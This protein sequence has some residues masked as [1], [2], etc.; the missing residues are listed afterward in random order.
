MTKPNHHNESSDTKTNPLDDTWM[1]P[2][3]QSDTPAS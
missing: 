3:P 2:H 1:I